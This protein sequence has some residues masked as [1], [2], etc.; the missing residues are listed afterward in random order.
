MMIFVWEC[1]IKHAF[2]IAAGILSSEHDVYFEL[3]FVFFQCCIRI[4]LCFRGFILM[5]QWNVRSIE[6]PG[7]SN[8]EKLMFWWLEV[9]QHITNPIPII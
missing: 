8:A 4:F 5:L 1:S 6:R 9:L 3:F 2:D 7:A